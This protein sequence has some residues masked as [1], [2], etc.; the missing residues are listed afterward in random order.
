MTQAHDAPYTLTTF[1]YDTASR[2]YFPKAVSLP[3]GATEVLV[4]TSHSG[5]CFTDVHAKPKGCGLGHEGVGHVLATGAAVS[6]FSVG[7][8]VGWG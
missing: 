4:R 3:L 8:R 7:D 2:N 1:R 5:I 6:S